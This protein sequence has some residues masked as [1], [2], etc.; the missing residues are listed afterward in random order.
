MKNLFTENLD[1]ETIQKTNNLKANVDFLES[2]LNQL[3]ETY[4]LYDVKTTRKP[5]SL[6]LEAAPDTHTIRLIEFLATD[7]EVIFKTSFL[8]FDKE[9]REDWV[10]KYPKSDGRDSKLRV[11][12]SLSP[13]SKT[14]SRDIKNINNCLENNRFSLKLGSL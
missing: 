4:L 14:L 13:N 1:K 8:V 9:V 10:K 5:D 6:C 11:V 12:I 3:Q 7:K 2:L